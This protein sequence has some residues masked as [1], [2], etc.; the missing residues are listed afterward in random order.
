M[1]LEGAGGG[2]EGEEAAEE[3]AEEEA[4]PPGEVP[5]APLAGGSSEAAAADHRGARSRSRSRGPSGRWG[6]GA[7]GRGSSSS[8]APRGRGRGRGRGPYGRASHVNALGRPILGSYLI[9]GRGAPAA[10]IPSVHWPSW[11]YI[12][13]PSPD[14]ALYEAGDPDIPPGDEEAE[15]MD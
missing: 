12:V 14:Q 13:A 3:A 15:E 9:R 1:I 5:S 8:A 2:A 6:R 4:A 11:P 7:L 10:E